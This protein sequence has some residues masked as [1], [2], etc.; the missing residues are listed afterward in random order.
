[1]VC[2]CENEKVSNTHFLANC[3]DIKVLNA[4]VCANYFVPL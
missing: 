1:M 2:G 3:L 4:C